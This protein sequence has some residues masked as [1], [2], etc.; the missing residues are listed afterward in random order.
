MVVIADVMILIAIGIVIFRL[1]LLL[2]FVML[3]LSSLFLCSLI[4]SSHHVSIICRHSIAVSSP[5]LHPLLPNHIPYPY[6]HHHHPIISYFQ[7]KSSSDAAQGPG[8]GPG[9][10]MVAPHDINNHQLASSEVLT[11]EEQ[12]AL[13]MLGSTGRQTGASSSGSYRW[14]AHAGH[15][16]GAEGA[17]GENIKGMSRS[18]A[19]QAGRGGGMGGRGGG[20]ESYGAASSSSSSAYGSNYV[21]KRCGRPGHF[22]TNC[23]SKL[24]NDTLTAMMIHTTNNIL[25]SYLLL[26]IYYLLPLQYSMIWYT[27]F[28]H[29]YYDYYYFICLLLLI[30]LFVVCIWWY[31]DE[32]TIYVIWYASVQFCA[33]HE[34]L[35]SALYDMRDEGVGVDWL[36][37]WCDERWD[38][39]NWYVRD[40]WADSGLLFDERVFDERV[41]VCYARRGV[42]TM[43]ISIS[44]QPTK[45]KQTN[46]QN[47]HQLTTQR[48][49]WFEMRWFYVMPWYDMIFDDDIVFVT[50]GNNLLQAKQPTKNFSFIH[51]CPITINQQRTSE[52]RNSD[53]Q[54]VW[55]PICSYQTVWQ[56][57][58]YLHNIRSHHITSQSFVTL[59]PLNSSTYQNQSATA[60]LSVR[61]DDPPLVNINTYPRQPVNQSSFIMHRRQPINTII[62]INNKQSSQPDQ[63]SDMSIDRPCPTTLHPI[64]SHPSD[65]RH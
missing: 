4:N 20:S 1:L 5:V 48:I 62:T 40:D 51:S 41:Y 56:P 22:V 36:R 42:T 60:Y 46:K 28:T 16:L 17:P 55:C 18:M 9:E 58:V 64:T 23:P 65:R 25:Q 63:L 34:K 50:S 13:L 24:T 12:Q 7:V 49:I 8:L 57:C 21:C 45:N 15:G 33:I 31:Y 59:P 39:L 47:K 14:G 37:W 11:E 27:L 53:I 2:L 3:F 26:P 54:T 19:G 35:Y 43:T 52:R 61:F 6:S 30:C 44:C 38:E 10:T 29:D 32:Y